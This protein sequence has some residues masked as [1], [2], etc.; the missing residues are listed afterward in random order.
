LSTV[1]VTHLK[2]TKIKTKI[3]YISKLHVIRVKAEFN[4]L[5]SFSAFR[6]GESNE[7]QMIATLY[8]LLRYKYKYFTEFFLRCMLISW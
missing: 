3:K 5:V 8:K 1:K 2:T 7:V 6:H 4:I